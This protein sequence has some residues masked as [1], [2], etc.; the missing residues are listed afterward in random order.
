MQ[1]QVFDGEQW[2]D[3]HTYKNDE[4][5]VFPWICD[6]YGPMG[7]IHTSEGFTSEHAAISD[8]IVQCASLE[9]S[10]FSFGVKFSDAYSI[11]FDVKGWYRIT[12][13][14]IDPHGSPAFIAMETDPILCVQKAIE[15]VINKEKVG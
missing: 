8:A 10:L 1:Y 9:R 2:H 12:V 11:E 6:V 5:E 15:F 4:R 14:V 3:L 7:K 13:T